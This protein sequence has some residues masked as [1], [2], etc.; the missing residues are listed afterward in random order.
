MTGHSSCV[1]TLCVF[2][3]RGNGCL[4]NVTHSFS[5][6]GSAPYKKSFVSKTSG[7]FCTQFSTVSFQTPEN[8]F[9]E[10]WGRNARFNIR[11]ILPLERLW[12]ILPANFFARPCSQKKKFVER[13]ELNRI[14]R[15]Q[16][17]FCKI[18]QNRQNF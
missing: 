13:A 7:Y 5:N 17:I 9:E 10:V 16:P 6:R 1:N 4:A 15:N 12:P 11:P 2:L 14:F 3:T 8:I 18:F